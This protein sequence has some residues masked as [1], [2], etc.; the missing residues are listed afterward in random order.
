MKNQTEGFARRL[1][2]EGGRLGGEL[3]PLCL[4]TNLQRRRRFGSGAA[5]VSLAE[6]LAPKLKKFLAVR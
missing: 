2:Y 3:A 1:G 5:L 6:S 4:A